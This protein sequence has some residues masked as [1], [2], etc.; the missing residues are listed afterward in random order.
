[1]KFNDMIVRLDTVDDPMLSDRKRI[2]VMHPTDPNRIKLGMHLPAYSHHRFTVGELR[3]AL[4]DLEKNPMCAMVTG[5]P[6]EK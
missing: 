3:K 5:T 1:M 6:Q 4:D 2:T